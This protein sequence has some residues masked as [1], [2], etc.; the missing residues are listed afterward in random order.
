MKTVIILRSVSGAGKSTFAN[1]LKDSMPSGLCEICCADDYLMIDGKYIWT[2]E[3]AGMAHKKCQE[4]FKDCIDMDIEII[5]V[6]NTN[7]K[8]REWKYYTD[9]A[10]R[11]C[12]KVTY[13][14]LEN[15]HGNKNVHDV[16]D[17]ALQ[18]QKNSILENL[19]LL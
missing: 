11:N 5:I 6:A 12:Y 8:P 17:E 16:P 19:S 2:P 10:A 3:R 18:R 15:R 1:L 14:I 9:L 7:T 13:V 4:K